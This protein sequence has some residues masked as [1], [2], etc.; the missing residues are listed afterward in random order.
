VVRDTIANAQ[1]ARNVARRGAD[2]RIRKKRS[3]VAKIVIA[4]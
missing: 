3:I 1:R 4:S 2:C